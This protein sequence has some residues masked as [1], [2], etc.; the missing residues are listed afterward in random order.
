MAAE[1]IAGVPGFVIEMG[2]GNGRTYDHLR[3]ILPDREIFVFDRQIAAHPDCV[4]DD[5]HVVL[6]DLFQTLPQAGKRLGARAAL[7][8]ADI[9]TGD[10]AGNSRTAAFLGEHLPPLMAP[11]G[12]ILS[13]QDLAPPGWSSLAL[14]EGVRPGRYFIFQRD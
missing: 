1:R 5:D 4:P 8:H 9:G 6:G 10:A 2:L 7:V 13:D 12:I 14:P 3:E 11:G